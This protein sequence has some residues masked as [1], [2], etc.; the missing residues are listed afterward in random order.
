MALQFH[1]SFDEFDNAVRQHLEKAAVINSFILGLIGSHQTSQKPL[2]L[3]LS[4]RSA[5][6]H[7]VAAIQTEQNRPLVLSESS[8]DEARQM[9]SALV[10][11][12]VNLPG[13]QGPAPAVDQFARQWS[14]E[15]GGSSK[16]GMDLRLFELTSVK[17]PRTC[18]GIARVAR[19]ED[20]Q[21]IV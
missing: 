18:P 17:E 15:L 3:M 13:I 2:R 21:I 11:I 10:G 4:L 5:A 6:G 12:V 16:L 14:S 20:E 1:S 7:L 19:A 9:A 8:I